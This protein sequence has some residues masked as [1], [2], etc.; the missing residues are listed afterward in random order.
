MDTDALSV[1]GNAIAGLLKEVFGAEVTAE[2]RGC[3]SCGQTSPVGAH[4]V[5]SGAGTVMRCPA[6]GDLAL[7]IVECADRYVVVMAG[8]W[9]VGV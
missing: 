7:R 8:T 2:P 6:C 1:D 4:R 3:G 9:T 5:Y